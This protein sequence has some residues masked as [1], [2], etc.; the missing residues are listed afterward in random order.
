ME[1]A[2]SNETTKKIYLWTL[3]LVLSL[4]FSDTLQKSYIAEHLR[5]SKETYLEPTLPYIYD[6]HCV[7]SVRIRSFP[8]PYFSAF[9]PEKLRIQTLFTQW[10]LLRENS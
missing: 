10:E 5:P 2:L 6:G 8:G 9:R 3:P 7:K 1:A 4:E